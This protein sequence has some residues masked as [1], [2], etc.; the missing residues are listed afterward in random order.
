MKKTLALFVFLIFC[1]FANAQQLAWEMTRMNKQRS[2]KKHVPPGNY[3]GITRLEGSLYAVVDD[4]SAHDGYYVFK[5]DIDSIDGR[6]LEVRRIEFRGNERP[7]RDSEGIAFDASR[8]LIYISGERDHQVL[9]YT[10]DGQPTGRHLN[11][12]PVFSTAKRNGSLESLAF[13]TARRCFWVTTE[14]PLPSDSMLSLRMQRFNALLEPD[15]ELFYRMDEPEKHKRGRLH[16]HGVSEILAVG[17]DSLL[18]LE[19]ELYVPKK[20]I[21]SFVINKLYL[22]WKNDGNRTLQ[23][24]LVCR[25]KT[26]MNLT[27]RS[28]ANYEG[29]SM[30]PRLTD[31]SQVVLLVSD[32]QNQYRGMMRDWFRTII[33]K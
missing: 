2:F 16:V 1:V 4:K 28:F 8:Q 11:M 33:V 32:S 30:G 12:P 15:L 31:G 23:K 22:S 21:G 10:I 3:S 17:T 26:R 25:W 14:V 9:E 5:I 27:N 7:N 18:V 13:D 24:R 29:M 20:Q 19:R 6:I